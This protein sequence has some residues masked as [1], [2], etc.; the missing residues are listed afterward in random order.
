M[1]KTKGKAPHHPSVYGENKGEGSPSSSVY[2][3][4]KGE[5]SPSSLCLWG[6]QRGRLPIIPLFMGKTIENLTLNLN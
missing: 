3:E 4:N 6:K 2:G 5:G 1:G